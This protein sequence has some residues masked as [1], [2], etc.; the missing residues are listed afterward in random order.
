MEEK[1]EKEIIIEALE[2]GPYIVK[3]NNNVIC[4]LCRCGASKDKPYCDGSHKNIDFKAEKK[5]IKA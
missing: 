1:G 2:N 4:A 5:E 3:V